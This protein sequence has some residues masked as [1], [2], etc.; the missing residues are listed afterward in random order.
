LA[1][2]ITV[3]IYTFLGVPVS[4]SQAVIGVVLGAGI[5]K[6]IRTVSTRTLASILIGWFLTL[7]LAGFIAT[8]FFFAIQL[9]YM[10]AP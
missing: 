5:V 6:G 2:A 1:E 3:H 4:T 9:R 10:P 8:A 7:V